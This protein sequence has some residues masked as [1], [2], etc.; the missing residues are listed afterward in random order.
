MAYF[1][2]TSEYKTDLSKDVKAARKIPGEKET[3]KASGRIT[4]S[5][6]ATEGPTRM[7]ES[8]D[9]RLLVAALYIGTTI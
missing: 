8:F 1:I 4:G 6:A 5:T 3:K 2:S 7:T 9:L